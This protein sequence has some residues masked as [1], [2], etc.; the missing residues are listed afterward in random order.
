VAEASKSYAVCAAGTPS[1]IGKVW[2]VYP[3]SLQ[4]LLEAM[5]DARLQSFNH[6]AH[7]LTV[8]TGR[9]TEVIRRYEHGHE[10]W[11]KGTALT[12]TPDRAEEGEA[13]Q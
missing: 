1:R 7:V 3:Y 8:V 6:G 9:Q 11:R 10:V 2:K 4:S 5:E 13:A 12:G